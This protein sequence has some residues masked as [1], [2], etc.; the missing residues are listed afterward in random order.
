MFLTFSTA[1]HSSSMDLC[2]KSTQGNGRNSSQ[3]PIKYLNKR[4]G[5]HFLTFWGK[6][7]NFSLKGDVY[8][9]VDAV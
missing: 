3:S 8:L 2:S 1:G 6:Y 4:L 7:T 5:K 9:G